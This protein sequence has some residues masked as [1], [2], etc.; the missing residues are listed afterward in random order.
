LD[1]SRQ[2]HCVSRSPVAEEF[3]LT[4]VE[5]GGV[6]SA[7][8]LGY[9]FFQAPGGWLADRLVARRGLM[10]AV[11]WWGLFTAAVTLITPN[12]VAP[13]T[14]LIVL[15]LLLGMGEA[16]VYPATNCIVAAWIPS[17]ERGMANG[18]I[19]AGV[20]FGA[21][22]TPPIISW[23]LTHYCWPSFWA[24]AALG[25]AAGAIWY[26]IARDSSGAHPWVSK[27]EKAFI[28]SGLPQSD[29]ATKTSAGLRSIVT[30][31]DLQAITFSYFCYGY[32]AYIFFTW[33]FIYLNKVR[34]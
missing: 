16:V 8:V 26:V 27:E 22:I 25:L 7:F 14:T 30:N 6:F 9:A 23:F 18:I 3:H 4:N 11:I 31:R 5:L 13:L 1:V 19:F 2:R 34:G 17:S 10:L 15:R 32:T 33:V 28:T 12:V 20:G 29:P 24:S 21:G